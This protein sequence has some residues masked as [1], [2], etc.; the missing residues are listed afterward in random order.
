RL[1]PRVKRERLPHSMAVSRRSPPCGVGITADFSSP[2]GPCSIVATLIDR[3]NR[4]QQLHLSHHW[5]SHRPR[6]PK[7]DINWTFHYVL[8]PAGAATLASE[9]CLLASV[10]KGDS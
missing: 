8:R 7:S 1:R 3:W 2:V 10:A 4:R 9:G 5:V 6:P